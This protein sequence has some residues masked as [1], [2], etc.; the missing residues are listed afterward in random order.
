MAPAALTGYREPADAAPRQGATVALFLSLYL[1][2]L[3]FFIMLVAISDGSSRKSRA[4]L[5]GLNSQFASRDAKTGE[6]PSF[7]S[8]LG[9]VVTPA[10]FLDTVT[11][12]YEAAIPAARITVVVPGREMELRV[13]VDS[14]FEHDTETLR[15]AQRRAFAEMVAA[16][17]APPAGMRYAVEAA[18]GVDDPERVLPVA[19]D[20]AQ[21]RAAIVARAFAE[22]GAPPGSVTAALEPGDPLGARLVFRVEDLRGAP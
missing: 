19:S 20:R 22:E 10:E 9:R 8:D 15:P 13:H 6:T 5:E 12:V 17:S 18:F 3:A 11:R 16:L 2:L 14:L 7:A 4:I 21:R 1:V